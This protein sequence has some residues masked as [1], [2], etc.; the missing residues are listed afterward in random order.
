MLSTITLPFELLNEVGA[1]FT[2][3]EIITKFLC[4]GCCQPLVHA[5]L[6]LRSKPSESECA[7]Y[8]VP[9]PPMNSRVSLEYLRT[10]KGNG[11]KMTSTPF[12]NFST[13]G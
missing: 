8:S 5:K 3:T 11:T 13:G 6:L 7:L 12:R 4:L 10:Y 1:S 2:K 9:L